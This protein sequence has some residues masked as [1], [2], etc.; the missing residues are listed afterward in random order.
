MNT[1]ARTPLCFRFIEPAHPFYGQLM[2]FDRF[3]RKSTAFYEMTTR[4]ANG[5]PVTI[6]AEIKSK[7]I[8]GK[9]LI[10]RFY[11]SIQF[12][13]P[14]SP[15]GWY[16][17]SLHY[18]EKTGGI[19]EYEFPYDPKLPHL[20][21]FILAPENADIKVLRYVPLR[22]VTFLKPGRNGLPDLIGKLKKPNRANDGYVRLARVN[23]A[24]QEFGFATPK[25][26]VL[27]KE[28]AVFYQSLEPGC[29]VT[30]LLD[31]HNYLGLLAGIGKLHGELGNCS[32]PKEN[33][34]DRDGIK[35]SL[36]HDLAEIAFYLP[37]KAALTD[38]IG[39]WLKHRSVGFNEAPCAFCHGDF[40]CS[41]IL[42]TEDGWSIV[43]FDLSGAG[44]P[45]QDIA[46]FMVS[47]SHDVALFQNRQE[48]LASAQSAYLEAFRQTSDLHIEQGALTWYLVCAE[49][50]YLALILK[51][52]R[53]SQA[54]LDSAEL[55]LSK[56]T[57]RE[58]A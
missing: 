15:A 26:V 10:D 44:D 21:D 35:A 23:D 57:C 37:E 50:Y 25:A 29:E 17:W 55:R 51:K 52:D 41:Q 47:L 34:W 2:E 12:S 43:D 18:S 14:S 49:I 9:R 3:I 40:A 20:A 8:D 4:Q 54:A 36:W 58:S 24:R 7:I 5:L 30:D 56:L 31:E 16:G 48:L 27:D 6:H 39:A 33:R 13:D 28:N 22:R 32:I 53:F 45:Y 38:R 11:Y 1:E 19:S 46:M 42:R